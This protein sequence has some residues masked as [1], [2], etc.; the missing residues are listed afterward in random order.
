MSQQ[1]DGGQS[2]QPQFQPGN[3]TCNGGYQGPVEDAGARNMAIGSLTLGILSILTAF[4][5]GILGII[6]IAMGIIGIILSRK[7]KPRLPAGGAGMATAG[8]VCSIVGLCLSA[9]TLVFVL[10]IVGALATL[11]IFAQ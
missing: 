3:N 4:S 1:Q 10:F 9:V 6:G 11:G 7:A 2:S 8:F 5:P